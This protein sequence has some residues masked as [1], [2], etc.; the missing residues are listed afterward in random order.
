MERVSLDRAFGSF[1]EQ[2]AT[3]VAA[4]LNG[5]AVK[6]VKVEGE[7]VWHAHEDADEFPCSWCG[8]ASCGSS[9]GSGR[10]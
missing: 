3:R 6:V 1:G 4:A 2:W 10:T 8:R 9:S 5:Q 7:F